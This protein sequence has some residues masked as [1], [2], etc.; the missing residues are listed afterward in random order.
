M[1]IPE[2]KVYPRT[3]DNQTVYLKNIITNPNIIIGDYT[4]YSDFVSDPTRFETNNVLYQYPI[5]YDRC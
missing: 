5:N 1:T 3:N 2:E 4:I